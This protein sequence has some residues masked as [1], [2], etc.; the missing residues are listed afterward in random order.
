MRFCSM[1]AFRTP[2]TSASANGSPAV[3]LMTADPLLGYYAMLDQSG[4]CG[5]VA[6][7][8]LAGTDLGAFWLVP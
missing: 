8:D 2:M 4:A 5:L 6:K 1:C 3:L 7:A